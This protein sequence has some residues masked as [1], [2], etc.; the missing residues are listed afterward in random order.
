MA[1]A[2]RDRF[3][4]DR[5]VCGYVRH[6]EPGR[7]LGPW[8]PLWGEPSEATRWDGPAR[9]LT[10]PLSYSASEDAILGLQGLPHV[11][12]VGEPSGGGSGRNRR[13]RLLPGWRLTISTGITWDARG[14]R[15]ERL[16][17]PVDVPVTVDRAHPDGSD[18]VL[19]A[20]EAMA[21]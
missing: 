4:P 15:V 17:V 12:V 1:H 10:S 20:A 16:G 6:T 11:Q 13:L 14:R 9:F 21:W 18:P 19:A 2:L 7:R 5:R 8:E 3:L